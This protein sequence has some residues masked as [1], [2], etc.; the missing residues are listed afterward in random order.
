MSTSTDDDR[1]ALRAA[2]SNLL[3]DCAPI[4]SL[5]AVLSE[6]D[7][8]SRDLWGRL[9]QLGAIGM[10]VPEPLGGSGGSIADI[11]TVAAELG[12]RVVPGPFLSS[13]VAATTAVAAAC[14]QDAAA[15]LAVAAA[16]ASGHV[17][18]SFAD[19]TASPSPLRV[20]AAGTGY[21][22]SGR[23]AFVLGADCASRV[24][25]HA[26]G[27]EDVLLAVSAH[28]L[29]RAPIR[30]A[31]QTRRAADLRFE[32]VQ[33][34]QDGVLATGDAALRVVAAVKANLAV[35]IAAD[36]VGGARA[37][38]RMSTEYA[39]TREQF[40]R[41]IGSFQA[42]KHKLA[43]M[44]IATESAAAI[45]ATAADQ[46]ANGDPQGAAAATTAAAAHA[47]S[48]YVAV[49]GDAIQVHGGIGF[50]WEHPCYRYFK[51]A[52]LNQMIVG[53][54]STLDHAYAAIL[55]DQSLHSPGT[56]S[57]AEPPNLLVS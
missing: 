16:L 32:E 43:D 27:T 4:S 33:V 39:K 57:L 22:L 47:T 7:G 26:R 25:V 52:W 11:A 31:D 35:S 37:A 2:V 55:F 46:L 44:Y 30:L 12:E 41:P 51:R 14:G 9:A 50:T 20:E 23:I 24:I 45:V 13:A 8:Y 19:G 42:I 48:A 53:G 36:S 29:H 18:A 15:T 3:D 49:A 56:V 34:N 1:K 6:E 40:G 54:R 17:T 28:V 21:I 5:P 38:L 10:L